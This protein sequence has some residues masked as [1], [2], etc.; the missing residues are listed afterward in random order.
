MIT[1]S[2]VDELDARRQYSDQVQENSARL[3]QSFA[4]YDTTGQGSK[5]FDKKCKF[6]VTFIEKPIVAYCAELDLDVLGDLQN[7]D[8][9]EMPVLPI[10]TGFVCEWDTDERGYYTGCWVAVRVYF[11]YEDLID[12]KMKVEVTHNF[13]FSAVALKDVPVDVSH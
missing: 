10:C 4:T 12:I 1:T 9:G 5:A 11:P 13:T 6:G 7:V 2:I 3:A 8:A